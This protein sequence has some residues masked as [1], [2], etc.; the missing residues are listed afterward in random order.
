MYVCIIIEQ[1]G[2]CVMSK[3]CRSGENV[4]CTYMS[5]AP[6]VHQPLTCL[7]DTEEPDSGVLGKR[8][9]PQGVCTFTQG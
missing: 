3:R 5:P 2:K 1:S 8:A 7:T 9:P 4:T 6:G